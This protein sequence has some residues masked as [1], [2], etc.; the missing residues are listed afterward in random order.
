MGMMFRRRDESYLLCRWM[1]RGK[2]CQGPATDW[3]LMELERRAERSVP[4]CVGIPNHPMPSLAWRQVVSM[5]E[6]Q[7]CTPQPARTSTGN[8]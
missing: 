5:E 4:P 1:K 6:P 7:Y 8:A 2:K 3:R